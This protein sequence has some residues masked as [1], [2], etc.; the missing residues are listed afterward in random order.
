MIHRRGIP[1]RRQK[2]KRHTAAHNQRLAEHGRHGGIDLRGARFAFQASA[3]FS[4][5]SSASLVIGL[6]STA[7]APMP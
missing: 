5:S 2:G 6:K 3:F 7:W 1:G 4:A